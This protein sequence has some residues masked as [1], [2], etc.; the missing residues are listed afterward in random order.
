MGIKNIFS[1]LL[2]IVISTLGMAQNQKYIGL[3][4]GPKVDWY[5]LATGGSR[6]YSPSLNLHN[7]IGASFGIIGGI[8]IDNKILLETAIIKSDFRTNIDII[9]EDGKRYFVNTPINTFTSYMIPFNFNFIKPIQKKYDTHYWYSGIGITTLV[10]KKLGLDQTYISPEVFVDEND[11]TQG[12]IQYTITGNDF[13]ADLIMFNL[14]AGYQYPLNEGI[15]INVSMQL[16][17]GVAGNNF[18]DLTYKTPQ[19]S[20]I[21]NTIYTSGSGIQF[22]IGFRYFIENEDI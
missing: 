7:P 22:N 12:S 6:P 15:M 11:L 17:A 14:N 9:N 1:F 19:Y 20:A 10:K 16:R 5:R 13:D 2:I 4:I 8:K 3:D 21:Q 18:F